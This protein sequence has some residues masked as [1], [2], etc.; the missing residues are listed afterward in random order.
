M[1]LATGKVLWQSRLAGDAGANT[2]LRVGPDGT[3]YALAADLGWMPVATPSGHP[4]SMAAQRR[5]AGYLPLAGG[6]RLVSEAYTP[7]E[8]H[9]PREA[10]YALL[11]RRGRI[12]RAWR[13]VSRTN[14]SF[15][16]TT[17]ALVGGDL[18]VVLDVTAGAAPH[19]K[20][21]YQVLRLGSRGLRAGFSLKR[22]VYGD[23]L[24]ADVRV[25]PD[26]KLYQLASSP[27]TGVTIQRFSLGGAT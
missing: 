7:I 15:N 25:G 23:N 20:W 16:F 17:P 1:D 8:D 14:V 9:A 13:V 18:V 10:R 22:A 6:L 11:D 4:V 19:F 21:E 5:Q 24:L 26:G 3:L 2:Q 27:N 12:A